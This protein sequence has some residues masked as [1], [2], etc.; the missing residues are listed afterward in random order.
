MSSQ[1]QHLQ[2]LIHSKP[3]HTYF[4][5]EHKY[6][7]STV[8]FQRLTVTCLLEIFTDIQGQSS[9]SIKR[10]IEVLQC[11]LST[12]LVSTLNDWFN[13][14]YFNPAL[15]QQIMS[16]HNKYNINSVGTVGNKHTRKAT[17]QSDVGKPRKF[18]NKGILIRSYLK[19]FWSKVQMLTTPCTCSASSHMCATSKQF[20]W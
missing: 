10:E 16:V 14:N 2:R 20:Q 7:C 9:K 17:S 13:P 19:E 8:T 1:Q 12:V 18:A 6:G 5:H 3:I 15:K 11:F 4:A